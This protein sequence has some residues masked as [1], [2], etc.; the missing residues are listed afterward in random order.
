[1]S[2]NVG[3]TDCSEYVRAFNEAEELLG[4]GNDCEAEPILLN[5][6][7]ITGIASIACFRLGEIYNRGAKP[8]KS[9]E[10]HTKAFELDPR[11]ACRITSKEH[12]HN[13]YIFKKVD[14]KHVSCCPLCDGPGREHWVFNMITNNDFNEG[15]HPIRIWMYCDSC[16]HIFANNYPS[17]LGRVLKG[18]END[19][20]EKPNTAL[21]HIVGEIVSSISLRSSGNRLLEVGVGAGEM[22]AV[23]KEFGF[24]VTGVE[25][26]PAHAKMVSDMLGIE[27]VQS[28]FMEMETCSRYDVICM[29][30]VI[31]HMPDPAIALR[32][33]RS[34]LD[35][36]GILWI[37]T[38]NFDS[39][40]SVI[41]G[42]LDPMK[43]VCEHLN[44]FSKVSIEGLLQRTG[45]KVVDYRVSGHYNGSMEVLA[46]TS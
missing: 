14:Q 9:I 34:M 35:P 44:Y 22:S 43:R 32:K 7:G 40:F 10:Y 15:F 28:D 1:M 13:G 30:D 4:S 16:H 37:S 33:A 29:G 21:L 19:Q 36:G 45:F 18:S 12:V 6:I 20:Y 23:A 24:D 2:M 39:A 26:R 8:I 17:E 38:P 46:E 27:V 42:D 25:I 41:T 31:E 3:V 5:L 11:L